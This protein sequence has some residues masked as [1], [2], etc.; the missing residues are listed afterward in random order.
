MTPVQRYRWL[1]FP[2]FAILLFIS[3]V[4]R[5]FTLYMLLDVQTG[6]NFSMTLNRQANRTTTMRQDAADY[7]AGPT[8]TSLVK[9]KTDYAAW[10]RGSDD[11]MASLPQYNDDV[12]SQIALTSAPAAGIDQWVAVIENAKPPEPLPQYYFNM[13]VYVGQ[14]NLA[15][16]GAAANQLADNLVTLDITIISNIATGVVMVLV[17]GFEY[18]YA[19]WPAYYDLRNNSHTTQHPAVTLPLSS[20][21]E[22]HE[23][24]SPQQ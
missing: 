20:L 11:L 1:V 16:N 14:Y 24:R 3:L 2:G 22:S 6:L 8:P 5:I 7:T 12:Q 4:V 15:I 10:K 19:L 21:E 18:V 17:F 23:Q 9:L 13:V